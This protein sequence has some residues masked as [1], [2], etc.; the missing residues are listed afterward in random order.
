MSR[1]SI[2]GAMM[3]ALLVASQ[4][5]AATST[6]FR[7]SVGSGVVDVPVLAGFA[8]PA[9]VP[10]AVTERIQRSMTGSNRLVAIALSDEFL[11][12]LKSGQPTAGDR[13]YTVQVI[14][15]TEAARIDQPSFEAA[16]VLLRK[17]M[18]DV[19]KQAN[20]KVQG[21]LDRYAQDLARD[22]P[23]Q[24]PAIRNDGIVSEGVFDEQPD[25][26]SFAMRAHATASTSNDAVKISSIACTTLI[27]VDGIVFTIGVYAP[28]TPQA[29][30]WAKSAALDLASRLR[31][32]NGAHR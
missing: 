5:A 15:A 9:D 8:D 1:K 20:A 11:A 29:S 30:A 12:H 6:S 23:Q 4:A 19:V 22:D 28:A 3:T 14:K 16:K 2:V 26:L 7:A 24:Q 13:F 27:D 31:A 25:S 32:L 10:A 21:G 18:A 17:R